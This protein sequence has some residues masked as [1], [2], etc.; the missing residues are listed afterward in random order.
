[1]CVGNRQFLAEAGELRLFPLLLPSSA[2]EKN[3]IVPRGTIKETIL[4]ITQT[5]V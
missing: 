2:L 4:T 1:M 3:E 5:I